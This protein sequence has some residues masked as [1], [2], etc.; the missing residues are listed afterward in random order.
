MWSNIKGA[1]V[2]DQVE[3]L[4]E[5]D[6][7]LMKILNDT[8]FLKIHFRFDNHNIDYDSA[9]QK[10]TYN[11]INFDNGS[12]TT[13]AIILMK[14]QKLIVS[15]IDTL[16]MSVN[17]TLYVP[18][19]LLFTDPDS[20]RN[21]M[22][23]VLPDSIP[24]GLDLSILNGELM[25]VTNSCEPGNRSFQIEAIHD[26]L[27]ALNE[28]NVSIL[29]PISPEISIEGETTF[30]HGD[31]ATLISSLGSS[32]QWST[33]ETGSSI[34]V[35]S[36]GSYTVSVIDNNGCLGASDPI[37]ITVLAAPMP[38][39]SF[40][41]EPLICLGDSVQLTSSEAI[42]YTW[43]TGETTQSLTAYSSG[44]YFV[45]V[46]DSNGCLGISSPVI[47]EVYDLPV[48]DLGVDTIVMDSSLVL[49]AGNSGSSYI[50]ST[51][52]TTQ[53]I[54]ISS[55]GLYTVTVIDLNDC[56]SSDSVNVDF[57][58]NVL[59]IN[60]PDNIIIY[61]NPNDG[62]FILTGDILSQEKLQIKVISPLGQMVY[63]SEPEWVSGKFFKP[64]EL[65]RSIS[66][67]YY[68]I[69]DLG[70]NRYINRVLITN[71]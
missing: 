11:Y 41:I 3:S 68:V 17:D 62:S 29:S 19:S 45:T 70:M 47:V 6:V 10:L 54:I 42:S 67:V 23:F 66:G 36:E 26:D 51:A 58:T 39:I 7:Y 27:V 59:N 56:S 48:V 71:N 33:G 50:W 64:I 12:K 38:T 32:Y 16:Q 34:V 57:V 24:S 18:L 35:T 14:K 15:A 52:E 4:M 69:V 28:I 2:L 1:I 20:I 8:V 21:D 9:E 37:S 61:P 31:S 65:N 49:D 30:C 13:E 46:I 25:I 40:D 55:N 22:D 43:N 5:D 53:T 44:E 60:G 63:T